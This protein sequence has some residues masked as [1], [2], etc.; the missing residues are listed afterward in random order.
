MK[1][2][3]EVVQLTQDKLDK[4][5]KSYPEKKFRLKSVDCFEAF[6]TLQDFQEYPAGYIEI[7]IFCLETGDVLDSWKA[8]RQE[9]GVTNIQ[10]LVDIINDKLF[11]YYNNQ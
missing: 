3:K 9:Y 10:N 5:E 6:M 11:D 1:D 2:I 4:L 7:Q 8:C